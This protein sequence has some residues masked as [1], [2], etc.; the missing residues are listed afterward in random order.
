MIIET[1]I[2]NQEPSM[3]NPPIAT[4]EYLE[5]GDR[6]TFK[7]EQV[8]VQHVSKNKQGFWYLNVMTQEQGYMSFE[9][10]MTT[11]SFKSRYL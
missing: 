1:L 8:V 7:R 6:F 10:Y 5:I 3:D 11:Q 9:Y 4:F 2:P